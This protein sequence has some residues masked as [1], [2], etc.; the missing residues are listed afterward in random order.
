VNIDGITK[1]PTQKIFMLWPPL[2]KPVNCIILSFTE[3]RKCPETVPFVYC[4]FIFYL[5]IP[6]RKQQR[7]KYYV[8]L[9]E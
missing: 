3:S 7:V 1:K 4:S 2:G 9:D 5:F 6:Y 8:I